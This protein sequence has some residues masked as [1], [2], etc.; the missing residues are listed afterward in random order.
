VPVSL[1]PKEPI[2]VAINKYYGS[3]KSETESVDYVPEENLGV[4]RAPTR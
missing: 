1:A 3:A 2:V 4:E